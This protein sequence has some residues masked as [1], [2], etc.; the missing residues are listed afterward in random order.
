[1]LAIQSTEN[2]KFKL[3]KHLLISRKCRREEGLF[4]LDHLPAILELIKDYPE[5][6]ASLL[7]PED[8]VDGYHL[9]FSGE[10]WTFTP[11]LWRQISVVGSTSK[12]IALV[13]IPIG[14]SLALTMDN[15]KRLI[16]LDRLQSPANVGAVVRS[17]VAFGAGGV[18]MLPGTADPYHPD[19]LR[20]MAGRCM[21]IPFFE[22]DETELRPF[23]KGWNCLGLQS[24][25]QANIK[26]YRPDTDRVMI[27][28]GSEGHGL[29][30][31]LAYTPVCIPMRI[32]I[33]S[34][35]VSVA[36]GIALFHFLD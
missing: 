28:L 23:L 10:I 8:T 11:G 36:A 19:A 13:R 3:L 5:T 25:A 29:Q 21:D 9:T 15:A 31:S 16:L 30:T 35:N 4:L 32:P 12:M 17:A 34:L 6:I 14:K 18:L 1:M 26:T 7:I 24:D 27:I 2:T 20:A 22:V 33:D